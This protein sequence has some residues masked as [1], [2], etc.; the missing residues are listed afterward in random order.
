[1]APQSEAVSTSTTTA[2]TA[3]TTTTTTT[4]STTTTRMDLPHRPIQARM[5]GLFGA[6]VRGKSFIPLIVGNRFDLV[7]NGVSNDTDD[8]DDSDMPALE[9][10]DEDDG[11]L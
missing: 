8:S 10:C 5:P 4:T 3:T 7:S 9:G 6:S 2:T 11:D 1:M